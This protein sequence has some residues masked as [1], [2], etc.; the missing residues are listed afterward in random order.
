MSKLIILKDIDKTTLIY[1]GLHKNGIVEGVG[2]INQMMSNNI[3]PGTGLR[4]PGAPFYG[5][6]ENQRKGI[7]NRL[8]NNG[9]IEKKE[10]NFHITELGKMEIE[11]IK[12]VSQIKQFLF[13]QY[14]SSFIQSKYASHNIRREVMT[15]EKYNFWFENLK[16]QHWGSCSIIH[17]VK[18]LATL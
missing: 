11:K 4:A 16:T 1:I 3:R 10:E 9:F 7:I 12:N 18:I 2:G 15:E 14:K 17:D 6:P 13:V 5:K 8:L